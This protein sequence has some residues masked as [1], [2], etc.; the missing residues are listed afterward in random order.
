MAHHNFLHR[1]SLDFERN[2][3]FFAREF[4][5]DRAFRDYGPS[6]DWFVPIHH[7]KFSPALKSFLL[8]RGLAWQ[9]I[10]TIGPPNPY[11]TRRWSETKWI[12]VHPRMGQAIMS[13]IAAAVAAEKGCDILT[14]SGR[15]HS[16]LS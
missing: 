6:G 12:L 2:P 8:E 11:Q 1:L 9:P 13:T 4:S 16:V 7:G 10:D 15:V 3:D 5:R 14:E